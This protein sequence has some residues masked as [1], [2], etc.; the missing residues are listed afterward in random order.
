MMFDKGYVMSSKLITDYQKIY[1][2]GMFISDGFLMSDGM[3]ISDGM[4]NQ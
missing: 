1:G 2:L 3:F 4:F